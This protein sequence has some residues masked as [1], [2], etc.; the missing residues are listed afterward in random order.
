MARQKDVIG[1]RQ[2]MS[3][4]WYR[5][6]G[7]HRYRFRW[8]L[9]PNIGPDAYEVV[10]DRFVKWGQQWARVHTILIKEVK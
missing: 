2:Y 6:L 7:E 5:T 8:T 3:R 10:A 4:Q 1:P 9:K